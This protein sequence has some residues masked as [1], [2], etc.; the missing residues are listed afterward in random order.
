MRCERTAY[1][2][3]R[4]IL[5]AEDDEIIRKIIEVILMND[6]FELLYASSGPQVLEMAQ[7]ERPDVIVVKSRLPGINGLEVLQRLKSDLETA[8]IPVILISANDE[9]SETRVSMEFGA[10]AHLIKPFS[11]MKFLAHLDLAVRESQQ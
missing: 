8:T 6:E 3:M 1:R 7:H 2:Y 10:S 5:I 11:P 4:K 9:P